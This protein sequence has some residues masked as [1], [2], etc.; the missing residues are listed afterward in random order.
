MKTA[1][2]KAAKKLAQKAKK[3][4]AHARLNSNKTTGCKP[5]EFLSVEKCIEVYNEDLAFA[6]FFQ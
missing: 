1:E 4:A 5:V 3:Q 6:D 2:Q